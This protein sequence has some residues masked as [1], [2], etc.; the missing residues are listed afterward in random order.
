MINSI[1]KNTIREVL[2]KQKLN[3]LSEIKK[4]Q[5]KNRRLINGQN[6]LLNLFYDLVKLI[7]NNDNK[8]VSEDKI[9]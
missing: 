2:A 7:F 9:I 1:K 6:I 8:T 3:A 5:T 4:A